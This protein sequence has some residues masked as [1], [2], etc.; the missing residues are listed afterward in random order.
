MADDGGRPPTDSS[1]SATSSRPLPE[2]SEVSRKLKLVTASYAEVLDA[3]KHQDDKIG[4]LLTSIAFLTAA[5]IALAALEPTQILARRFLV[6]P[7]SLPLGL[8]AL[9][10]FLLGIA[11]SVMLLLINLSTPLRVPGLG[12]SAANRGRGRNI[13]WTGNVAASQIYFFEIAGVGVGE[14]EHKWD[15]T[16]EELERER[17]ESLIKETHNLG[18]RTSA[19]YDRTTEAV[20]LLSISLL[21]FALAVVFVGIVAISPAHDRQISLALWQ[22]VVVAAIYA[23]YCWIQLLTRVRYDRQAVDEVPEPQDGAE[24]RKYFGQGAYAVSLPLLLAWVLVSARSVPLA[25]WVPICIL[26]ALGS[27]VS[28][29]WAASEAGA[30]RNSTVIKRRLTVVALTG[31]LTAFAIASAIHDW[32]GWQLVIVSFV[33][34]FLVALTVIQPTLRGLSRRRDYWKRNPTS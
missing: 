28:F 8:I 19:K 2:D 30:S 33:I 5:T 10:V 22:R 26:L 29:W 13:T 15:A 16:C 24:R 34:L 7:F 32:Y 31:L 21:A 1:Q 17:L 12:G 14:W 4:Q 25:A 23:C 20:A 11:F 27:I 18:L 6:P 9:T 3:T